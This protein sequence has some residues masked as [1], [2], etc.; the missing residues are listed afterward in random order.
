M[1]MIA[2]KIDA[3][4]Y[5]LNVGMS[6]AGAIDKWGA[7]YESTKTSATRELAKQPCN[8]VRL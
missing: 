1:E 6:A 4:N 2:L 7:K 5:I 8:R 3:K